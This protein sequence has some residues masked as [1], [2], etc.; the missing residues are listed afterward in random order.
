MGKNHMGHSE[1]NGWG[2][3]HGKYAHNVEN[4]KRR[5]ALPLPSLAGEAKFF[6][7]FISAHKHKVEEFIFITKA[8]AKNR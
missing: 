5:H 2:A 1:N 8:V 6:A 3:D 7:R 4:H